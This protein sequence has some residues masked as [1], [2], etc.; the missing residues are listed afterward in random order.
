MKSKSSIQPKKSPSWSLA[1][2]LVSAEIFCRDQNRKSI[3]VS[4]LVSVSVL[5]SVETK[6][7]FGFGYLANGFPKWAQIVSPRGFFYLQ[8][9][10]MR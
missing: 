5:V 10:I 3:L 8:T 7:N 9:S 1:E 2:V 4:D 6:K